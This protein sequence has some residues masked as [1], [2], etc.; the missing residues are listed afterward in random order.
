MPHICE[1]SQFQKNYP[2]ESPCGSSKTY[3]GQGPILYGIC[4]G[5]LNFRSEVKEDKENDLCVEC[6]W[7]PRHKLR[8]CLCGG[9]PGTEMEYCWTWVRSCGGLVSY[10]RYGSVSLLLRGLCVLGEYHGSSISK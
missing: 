7:T 4:L 1:K 8:C 10:D 3:T 9:W 6:D 2:V 5:F